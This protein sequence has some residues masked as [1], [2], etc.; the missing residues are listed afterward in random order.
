MNIQAAPT[1]APGG[2]RGLGAGSRAASTWIILNARGG[3]HALTPQAADWLGLRLRDSPVNLFELLRGDQRRERHAEFRRFVAQPGAGEH[4]DTYRITRTRRTLRA[5][6]IRREGQPHVHVTLRLIADQTPS[7]NPAAGEGRQELTALARVAPLC[8][9]PLELADTLGRVL[10]ELG[11]AADVDWARLAWGEDP[12]RYV[13]VFRGE[14]CRAWP[15]PSAEIRLPAH[16]SLAAWVG[17]QGTPLYVDDIGGGHG[18]TP[19][20]VGAGV[21][22]AAYL[23][24]RQAGKAAVVVLE[25]LHAARA[26]TADTQALLNTVRGLLQNGLE[27]RQRLTALE[28]DADTDPL[29]DLDNR[30]SY[31]RQLRRALDSDAPVKVVMLDLDGLKQINDQHGHVRGDALLRTFAA[32]L[33]HAFR[34]QTQVFRFGGDEFALLN[35]GAA[36]RDHLLLRQLEW[37]LRS[38]WDAGFTDVSLSYGA[39]QSGSGL[40]AEDLTR[41]AD[42]QMYRHKQVGRSISRTAS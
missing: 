26:W 17:R 32:L 30:R 38:L 11:L 21:R 13:D 9:H 3:I 16:R 12:V 24:L 42:A 25:R 20:F 28:R 15:S 19:E 39:A 4:F 37:V 7:G 5:H 33:Q 35:V 22:S 40:A 29:T 1:G 10:T 23:P 18:Y 8:A 6:L 27:A 41:L 14:R 2:V 36:L 31:Q 34:P